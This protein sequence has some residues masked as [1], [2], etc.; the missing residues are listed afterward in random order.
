MRDLYIVPECFVDTSLVESL[1]TTDGVNHQKGCFTV[2]GVMDSKLGNDFAVGVIDYDKHRPEY[3]EQFVELASS[4]HLQLMKHR[5]RSH[6]VVYVKPAMD[7]FILS[8][9]AEAGIKVEDYGFPADLKA[10]THVT[11]SVATKSD[12]RFKRLFRDLRGCREMQIL[13]RVLNH[14]RDHRFGSDDARLKAMFQ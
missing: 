13:S 5:S 10:F 4:A 14:L 3:L 11:K 12:P 2:A 7:G 8:Q 1:L 9:A 6:Y